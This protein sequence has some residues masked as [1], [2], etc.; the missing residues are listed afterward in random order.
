MESARRPASLLRRMSFLRLAEKY[1]ENTV[2]CFVSILFQAA[3]TTPSNQ[4]RLCGVSPLLAARVGR[5]SSHASRCLLC[6]SFTDAYHECRH[7]SHAFHVNAEQAI[8]TRCVSASVDRW[9]HSGA[10][11][12]AIL[13]IEQYRV[14][15][16]ARRSRRCA[17][18]EVKKQVVNV[19]QTMLL[20][21][22]DQVRS[23][24]VPNI[25]TL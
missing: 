7:T 12:V 17:S 9:R 5:A 15:G 22:R 2:Y 1:R 4:H 25:S 14:Y 21:I 18:P 8:S 23:T 13:P 3:A 19:M 24:T 16:T 10:G 11:G 20:C 6:V